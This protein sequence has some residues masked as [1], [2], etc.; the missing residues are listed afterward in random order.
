MSCTRRKRSCSFGQLF[1]VGFHSFV[2]Q[3][4]VHSNRNLGGGT[5]HRDITRRLNAEGV[6]IRKA[7]ARSTVWAVLRNP[8]YRGVACFGKTL[9]SPR[10]RVMC[11]QRRRGVTT[12]QHDTRT[13]SVRDGRCRQDVLV[14]MLSPESLF[15]MRHS[16]LRSMATASKALKLL[17][18]KSQHKT[19]LRR[20]I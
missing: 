11:P 14:R 16:K 8:A 19:G 5:H 7:S 9:A 4:G 13:P 20:L 2:L 1:L 3:R 12:T 15:G 18:S 17:N 10:M 6:S